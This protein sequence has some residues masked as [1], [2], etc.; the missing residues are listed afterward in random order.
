MASAADLTRLENE[1][2]NTEYARAITPV[3]TL[4]KDIYNH[5]KEI[6]LAYIFMPLCLHPVGEATRSW[7]VSLPTELRAS[8]PSPSERS[9]TELHIDGWQYDIEGLW[10]GLSLPCDRCFDAYVR[11]YDD[12]FIY[13]IMALARRHLFNIVQNGKEV[14]EGRKEAYK[15]I[16]AAVSQYGK[17]MKQPQVQQIADIEKKRQEDIKKALEDHAENVK[18]GAYA[19]VERHCAHTM[20]WI[21]TFES[22]VQLSVSVAPSEPSERLS[23]STPHSEGSFLARSP[24]ADA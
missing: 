6:D 18:N 3:E 4:I 17:R 23:P 11:F 1:Y 24:S 22:T 8:R 21:A 13:Y 5:H 10:V 19:E 16:E 15:V 9:S 14:E 7:I 2:L 12:K 20:D